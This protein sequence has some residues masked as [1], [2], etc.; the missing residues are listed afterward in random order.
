VQHCLTSRDWLRVVR[1]SLRLVGCGWRRA[2]DLHLGDSHKGL[3]E[4]AVTQRGPTTNRYN[5]MHVIETLV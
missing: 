3:Q 4:A 5:R 1:F 2:S